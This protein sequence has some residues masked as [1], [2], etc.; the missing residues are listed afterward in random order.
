MKELGTVLP[1]RTLDTCQALFYVF[2]ETT[3]FTPSNNPL[4]CRH[5]YL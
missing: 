1:P 2:I 4:R 5:P 3:S